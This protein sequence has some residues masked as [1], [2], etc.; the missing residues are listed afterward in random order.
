MTL[1]IDGVHLLPKDFHDFYS[2]DYFFDLKVVVKRELELIFHSKA[3][4][5]CGV[6]QKFETFLEV[7]QS[8]TC[9]YPRQ[10]FCPQMRTAIFFTINKILRN[11]KSS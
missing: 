4:L 1:S 5:A 8:M 2:Q 9:T 10:C 3:N 11:A 6:L 7:R